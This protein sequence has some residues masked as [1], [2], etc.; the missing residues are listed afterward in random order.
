MVSN[1]RGDSMIFPKGGWETD[2]TAEEAA[3]RESFEEAGVRGRVRPLG[4][5][6]FCSKSQALAGRGDGKGLAHVFVM[7]VEATGIEE[8]EI[9]DEHR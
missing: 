3:Q 2:E 1:K 6:E 5:F 9:A 7:D 4:V 8:E